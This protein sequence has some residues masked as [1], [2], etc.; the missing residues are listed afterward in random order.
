M[1]SLYIVRHIYC[2]HLR[3]IYCVKRPEWWAEYSSK[4][5]VL[6]GSGCHCCIHALVFDSTLTHDQRNRTGNDL[7][8]CQGCKIW[9]RNVVPVVTCW[10]FSWHCDSVESLLSRFIWSLWH[11]SQ[12]IHCSLRGLRRTSWSFSQQLFSFKLILIQVVPNRHR[13]L[14]NS[15]WIFNTCLV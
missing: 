9:A 6:S 1:Q 4:L 2:K 10:H 13:E 14:L 11:L 3:I 7:N 12:F 5:Q 15:L 8:P